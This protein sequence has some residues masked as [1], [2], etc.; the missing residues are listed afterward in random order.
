MP[1]KGRRTTRDD[2]TYPAHR[3][4]RMRDVRWRNDAA[5][6]HFEN[7]R[8][9]SLL[10]VF[11]LR[12]KG[13]DGL[14]GRSIPM[15]KLDNLVTTHMTERLFQPERLAVI[16]SSLASRRSEKAD[17]VD[18]RIIALQREVT[19]ADDKLKRLYRLIEDGMIDMDDVLN[20]RLNTLKAD[21]DRAKARA[22]TGQIALVASHPDRPC[23]A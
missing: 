9:P 2:G 19:D 8:R 7:R 5:D 6:R 1:P 22:R 15:D 18:A 20:D 23:A 21:R 17:A 10:Y 4:R 16:L 12:P 11:D 13:Q 14:Q 3:S